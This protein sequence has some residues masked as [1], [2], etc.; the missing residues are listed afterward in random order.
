MAELCRRDQVKS[1]QQSGELSVR[2]LLLFLGSRSIWIPKRE[3][4]RAVDEIRHARVVR[5]A[6]QDR[7]LDLDPTALVI[8]ANRQNIDMEPTG[9]GSLASSGELIAADCVNTNHDKTTPYYVDES[10][11]SIASSSLMD[12]CHVGG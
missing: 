8:L 10:R 9:N 7:Q 1:D 5:F 11:W 6:R 12:G 2:S 3:L 4:S